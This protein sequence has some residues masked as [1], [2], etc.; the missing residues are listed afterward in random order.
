MEIVVF[1]AIVVVLFAVTA[2]VR[3]SRRRRGLEALLRRVFNKRR[4]E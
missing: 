1:T 2:L 3:E 4:K